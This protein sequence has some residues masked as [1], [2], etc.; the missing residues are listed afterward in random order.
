VTGEGFE[1]SSPRYNAGALTLGREL[2]SHSSS[3]ANHRRPFRIHSRLRYPA[4]SRIAFTFP[5]PQRFCA[6]TSVD[7]RRRDHALT[8]LAPPLPPLEPIPIEIFVHFTLFLFGF[9]KV[10]IPCA[11][12]VPPNK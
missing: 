6:V 11:D 10:K 8:I 2:V 5:F 1:P 3:L 7:I 4:N 9:H 12:V